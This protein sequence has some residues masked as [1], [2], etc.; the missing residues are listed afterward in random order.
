MATEELVNWSS[1]AIPDYWGAGLGFFGG[2]AASPLNATRFGRMVKQ[3]TDSC[4]SDRAVAAPTRV[5]PGAVQ[6]GVAVAPDRP[7]EQ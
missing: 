4:P 5:Q 3:A 6:T 1:P 7:A 2:S